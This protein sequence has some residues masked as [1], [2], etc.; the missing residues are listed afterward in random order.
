MGDNII[1]A[2]GNAFTII[3]EIQ[4]GRIHPQTVHTTYNCT[5]EYLA[6]SILKERHSKI[7]KYLQNIKR[8]KNTVNN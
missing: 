7:D 6:Y 2:G 5:Y 1:I 4:S 8:T 3:K